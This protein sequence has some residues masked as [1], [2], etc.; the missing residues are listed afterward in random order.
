MV[1]G[2]CCSWEGALEAEGGSSGCGLHTYWERHVNKNILSSFLLPPFLRFFFVNSPNKKE[3]MVH[4][5]SE[6]A[7][8]VGRV[9]RYNVALHGAHV[10]NRSIILLKGPEFAHLLDGVRVEY[11]HSFRIPFSYV[12]WLAPFACANMYFESFPKLRVVVAAP[13]DEHDARRRLYII[14]PQEKLSIHRGRLSPIQTSQT[15]AWLPK[16]RRTNVQTQGVIAKTF[17]MRTMPANR[18]GTIQRQNIV[19]SNSK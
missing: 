3:T 7:I 17:M 18:D 13:Y 6:C 16:Q 10:G 11:L 19:S 14:A 5:A 2:G 4:S 12:Y 9:N 8:P 1:W 15:R